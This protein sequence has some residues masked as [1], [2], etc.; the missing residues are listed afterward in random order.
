MEG[1]KEICV[2]PLVHRHAF[3]DGDLAHVFEGMGIGKVDNRSVGWFGRVVERERNTYMV[4]NRILSTR[5]SPTRVEGQYMKL[6]I[7]FT[8]IGSVR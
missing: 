7:D 2:S 1:D 6:Q 5:G 3:C 8:I 4:R